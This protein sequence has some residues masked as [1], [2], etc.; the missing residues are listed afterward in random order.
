M[1]STELLES[2]REALERAVA[3]IDEH[4]WLNS[5]KKGTNGER[6]IINTVGYVSPL[7]S[8]TY[9]LGDTIYREIAAVIAGEN[10]IFRDTRY[11]DVQNII[12]FND[13]YCRGPDHARQI[14]ESTIKR[15]V[16]QLEESS[17]ASAQ[18]PVGS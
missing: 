17:C 18:E 9:R 10:P 5:S 6:C 2:A 14:L 4:G 12:S 8:S 3:W 16:G 13:H 7:M 15:I 1:T 11:S